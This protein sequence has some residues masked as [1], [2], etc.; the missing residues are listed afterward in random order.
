MSSDSFLYKWMRN[1]KLEGYWKI[2]QNPINGY[3][4]ENSTDFYN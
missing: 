2:N 3:G 4:A 1:K